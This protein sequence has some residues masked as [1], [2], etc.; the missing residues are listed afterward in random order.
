[1]NC[2]ICG[3]EMIEEECKNIKIDICKEGCKGM[4][5]DWSELSKFDEKNEKVSEALEEAL[6]YPRASD[7]NRGPIKCP[8]CGINMHAHRYQSSK[9]VMVDECYT[10]GGFF[11]DSGELKV[12]RDTC[13]SEEEQEEYA[14]RI[15]KGIAGYQN[16]A[17]S[18]E[19]SIAV[20]RFA[21]FLTQKYYGHRII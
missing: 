7:D 17:R 3:K 13:M 12:I 16:L 11:L 10:C 20:Q 15:I 9:G 2:P 4:W 19:R 21:K 8:K 6:N 1:M 5:F 14:Q 18:K